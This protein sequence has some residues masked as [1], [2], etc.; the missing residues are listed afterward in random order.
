M[1]PLS[2]RSPV[3]HRLPDFR[4]Q[5][6]QALSASPVYPPPGFSAIIL[7]EMLEG[8]SN[9]SR[10]GISGSSSCH[11]QLPRA[12]RL[13]DLYSERLRRVVPENVNDLD[14][15]PVLAQL[16]VGAGTARR[17]AELER[18][19]C[20]EGYHALDWRSVTDFIGSTRLQSRR[21]SICSA[22]CF[23]MARRS[24]RYSARL[25]AARTAFPGSWAS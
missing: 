4:R 18:L 22:Q 12:L 3:I 24:L 15:D 19:Q 11:I 6:D 8:R 5:E 14:D 10:P 20:A 1:T 17:P 23:I 16:F 25:Y 7:D 13:L 21:W 9:G 2:A